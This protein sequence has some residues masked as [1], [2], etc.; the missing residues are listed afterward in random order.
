M[1]LEAR[2]AVKAPR[3]RHGLLLSETTDPKYQGA[4]VVDPPVRDFAQEKLDDE[5]DAYRAEY[6]DTAKMESLLWRVRRQSS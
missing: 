4:W 2:R 1:L 3:G 5:M 6:P